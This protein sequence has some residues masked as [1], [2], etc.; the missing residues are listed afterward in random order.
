MAYK[1]SEIKV[2]P[3][4]PDVEDVKSDMA[5]YLY[6]INHFDV[7]LG[8]MIQM[9]EEIG[10]LDNTIIVVTSDN[11]MPFP[12]AKA[13]VYEYGIHMPMA[14]RWGEKVNSGRVVD[15]LVSLD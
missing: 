14:V 8:R 6:E 12:R 9:L 15:D 4:L 3:F 10:E 5:D 13:N 7:H 1:L 11:G 2:P